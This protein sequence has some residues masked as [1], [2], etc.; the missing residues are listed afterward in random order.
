MCFVWRLFKHG[1]AGREKP[2]PARGR[3]ARHF[4]AGGVVILQQIAA[5]GPTRGFFTFPASGPGGFVNR[6]F[7]SPAPDFGAADLAIP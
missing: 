1:R 3:N 5:A 7:I 2:K 6:Y 4:A